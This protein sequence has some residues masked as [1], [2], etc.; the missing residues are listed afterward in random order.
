MSTLDAMLVGI[1]A[2]LAVIGITVLSRKLWEILKIV[3]A[4]KNSIDMQYAATI[5]LV[6]AATSIAAELAYMRSLTTSQAA[7]PSGQE[8]INPF[9]IPQRATIPPFPAPVLDR[10]RTAPDAELKDTD[11]VSLT[12]T[13]EDMAQ[14]EAIERLRSQGVKIEEPDEEHP[15]VTAESE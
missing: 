8:A 14:L 10:F 7:M 9:E 1:V 13:D 11:D 5:Q 12:Q 2:T 6:T 15:G 3:P 4:V